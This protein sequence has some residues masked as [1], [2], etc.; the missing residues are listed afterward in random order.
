MSAA[1]D[2]GERHKPEPRQVTTPEADD[3]G[4]EV[5]GIGRV[6]GKAQ[7]SVRFCLRD[8]TGKLFSYSHLYSIEFRGASELLLTFSSDRVAITGWNLGR[9]L[10]YLGDHKARL[11]R[12]G[13]L[14]E[15]KFKAEGSMGIE[16]I[17]IEALGQ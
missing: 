8:G 6:G 12:E 13:E 16:S 1:K 7:L 15:A 4:Q 5:V 2:W 3:D 9:L 14:N 10:E 17:V 11:V